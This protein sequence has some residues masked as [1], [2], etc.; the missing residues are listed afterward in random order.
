M[1]YAID[2][3][4]YYENFLAFRSIL[5][6]TLQVLNTQKWKIGL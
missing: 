3:I 2:F 1:D 4:A 6:L 5:L